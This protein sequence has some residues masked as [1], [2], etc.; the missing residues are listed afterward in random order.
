M[1]VRHAPAA[2]PGDAPRARYRAFTL[3]ELLVAVGII[4]L[5]IAIVLPAVQS[6]REAARRIQCI[7]NLRQIGF[8][9]HNYHSVHNM[10]PPARMMNSRGWS[11]NGMSCHSYLVPYLDQ[12]PLFNA[13]NFDFAD[14]ESPYTPILENRTARNT[15]LGVFLCPSDGSSDC[16]NNYRFNRG[17]FGGLRPASWDGPFSFGF[18]PSQATVTDGLSRTAFVS[19]HPAGSF[20][21]GQTDKHRDV[22]V[23]LLSAPAYIVSD[24][25]IIQLCASHPIEGWN[26]T[27]GRYW[28]YYSLLQTD[29]N[30]S[31]APN[32]VRNSCTIQDYGLHPPRSFHPGGVGVLFGDG[33]TESVSNGIDIN[34]WTSLGTR[35]AGD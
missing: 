19:E 23:P 33:H 17:R 24:S 25:E 9:L 35:D 18:L 2:R 20:V 22:T 14:F 1:I 3:I 7:S 10:F 31:G 34:V 29:Y 16:L 13:I 28:F 21:R 26:I 30:H 6:A 11:I 8:A 4:G 27:S 32:D 12:V 5:L 15:K